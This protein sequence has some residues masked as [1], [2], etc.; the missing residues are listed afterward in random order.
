MS[1]PVVLKDVVGNVMR[2]LSCKKE[3]DKQGIVKSIDNT[4][5][6]KTLRHIKVSNYKNNKLFIDVDSSG[7]LHK[8]NLE[9]N[10]IIV[11]LNKAIPEAR[12]E[13]LVLRLG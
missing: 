5:D 4:L 8:L 9:K 10:S 13:D 2:G 6:I 7:W 1:Y 3:I 12:I 11:S